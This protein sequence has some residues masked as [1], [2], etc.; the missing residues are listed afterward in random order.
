GVVPVNCCT[1][2]LY[3]KITFTWKIENFLLLRFFA[4]EKGLPNL[5]ASQALESVNIADRSAVKSTWFLRLRPY[6]HAQSEHLGQDEGNVSI[7]IRGIVDEP[8]YASCTLNV[9]D[10][11]GEE[12]PESTRTLQPT[13]FLAGMVG[14]GFGNFIKGTDEAIK[15]HLVDGDLF[16]KTELRVFSNSYTTSSKIH[17]LEERQLSIDVIEFA[18]THE[19][20]DIKIVCRDHVFMAS[21]FLLCAR[22]TDFRSMLNG[23]FSEGEERR[24]IINDVS[25]STMYYFLESLHT[26]KCSLFEDSKFDL[27]GV[28]QLARLADRFHF[29][30][31]LDQCMVKLAGKIT[32]ENIVEI[33][34]LCASCQLEQLLNAAWECLQT[35]SGAD[36]WMSVQDWKKVCNL[37]AAFNSESKTTNEL[38]N[39]EMWKIEHYT[40]ESFFRPSSTV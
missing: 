20:K 39:T 8:T 11:N 9:V 24:V 7:F 19:A 14:R 16:V 29:K 36:L 25:P 26:D 2:L 10:E 15:R 18:K 35:I 12:I 30:A 37:S 21:E 33:L 27:S 3:H 22:A 5:D 40:S 31:L 28:C 17:E 34:D 23:S 6:E 13:K 1:S 4:K 38:A 32:K